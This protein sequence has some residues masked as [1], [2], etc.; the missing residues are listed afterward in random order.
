MK[1]I[2]SHFQVQYCNN[3]NYVDNI[4]AIMEEF[5]DYKEVV[6]IDRK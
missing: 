2:N 3:D 1:N 4:K 6:L 5:M